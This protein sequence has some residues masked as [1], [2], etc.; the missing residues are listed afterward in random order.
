MRPQGQ[1]VWNFPDGSRYEGEFNKGDRS[2]KGKL[3]LADGTCQEGYF[4]NDEFVGTEK[5]ET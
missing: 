5:P 1:G 2:G 4:E 3:T